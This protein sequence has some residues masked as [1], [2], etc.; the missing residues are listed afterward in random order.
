MNACTVKYMIEYIYTGDLPVIE[1]R[2]LMYAQ[3]LI[4]SDKY[5]VKGMKAKLLKMDKEL[6]TDQFV[7][8]YLLGGKLN[9]GLKIVYLKDWH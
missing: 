4:A 9:E 3:L 7:Q 2:S 1:K 8:D 5:D 6:D